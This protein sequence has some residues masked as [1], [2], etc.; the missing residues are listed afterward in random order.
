MDSMD[1]PN[2]DKVKKKCLKVWIRISYG[3][4]KTLS[5]KIPLFQDSQPLTCC[6]SFLCPEPDAY[7][8]KNNCQKLGRAGR[9]H[10][11]Q[12]FDII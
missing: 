2:A 4:E 11:E 1:R 7:H 10:K 5:F 3:K 6:L 12:R 9:N 8:V